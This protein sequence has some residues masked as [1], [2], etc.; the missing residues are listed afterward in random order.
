VTLL[1][2]LRHDK[3]IIAR[4]HGQRID[5]EFSMGL[6]N[7]PGDSHTKTLAYFLGKI[8]RHSENTRH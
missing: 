7:G 4:V 3:T 6:V 8:R 5:G 2:N 1:A